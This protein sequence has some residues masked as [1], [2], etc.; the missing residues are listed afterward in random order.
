V[1]A[2]AGEDVMKKEHSSI[3]GGMQA[4]INTLEIS[5]MV[6]QKT[7]YNTTGRTSNPS[8]DHISRRYSNW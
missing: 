3:A 7:G 8:P 6:P 5:K 2:D 1:T 4:C